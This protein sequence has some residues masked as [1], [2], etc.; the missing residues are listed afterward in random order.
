MIPCLITQMP[1]RWTPQRQKQRPQLSQVVIQNPMRDLQL[2]ER[3][4][5]RNWGTVLIGTTWRAVEQR[6][7]CQYRQHLTSQEAKRMILS[8]SRRLPCPCWRA[9]CP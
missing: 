3:Q 6:F 7:L 5:D 9:N 4:A 8:C 2:E 1:R